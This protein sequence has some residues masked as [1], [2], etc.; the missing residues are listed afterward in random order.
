MRVG[1]LGPLE[2]TAAGESVEIGGVRL[3]V[4]L[5]RLA[6]GTGRVV[7]ADELS[8][9]LWPEEQPADRANAVRSLVARLRRSL[10]D[11]SVLRSDRGGYRLDLPPD[12]V[13]AH[14]FERL[15][16]AGRRALNGG[17]PE[18]AGPLL[19]EAL[20]LWRGP[21]LADAVGAP[22]ATA[23]AAGLEE[24]RLA[25]IEDRAEAD[26]ASGRHAHLV[27]ELSEAAIRHPLR[28]RLQGLL[29]RALHAQGRQAEALAGYEKIRFRLAEELG[30]D[31]GPELREIHR[32]LLQE[33][34]AEPARPQKGNLRTALTSFVGRTAEVRRVGASLAEGRLVTLVGPGGAGK[35]RL[36]TTVAGELAERWPGGAWLVELAAVTD[37]ADVPQAVLG[38]LGTREVG[39]L[40]AQGAPRDTTSRLAEALS[41]AETLIMLDNCEH[42]VEAVA[43]LAED[44]LGRCPELRVLAT[45]REPLGILGEV[46]CPVAPLGLPEPDASARQAVTSPAVR[47]LAE[48]AAAVR[49]GFVVTEENVA[50]VVEICRRLDGLPLAIELAAARMRSLTA[51]QVAE[52]LGDRF[53][54]LTGGSRT[55]LP[56][57]RTLRAVVDWSWDLLGGERRFAERL[58]VFPGGISVEAAERVCAEPGTALDLLGALVDRS[59]LQVVEAPQ[60][61]FRMLETIREYGLER[62][63]ENG[64]I[65]RVR[66]AH[67]AYFLD[68]AETAEPFLRE[69]RQLV[70]MA[71]LEAE[72]DNLLAALHFAADAGD[73]D[74]AVR[75]AA[76]L[77]TFWMMRENYAEAVVRLR[78]ALDVPGEVSSERRSAATAFHMINRMLSGEH[79]GLE[80]IVERFR[81]LAGTIDPDTEDPFLAL[82]EPIFTI[83]TDD[84]VRGVAAVERRMSHPDPWTRAM[85]FMIRSALLEN[86]GEQAGR[87]RDLLAATAGFRDL[88]DRWGLAQVL[89]SLAEAH[90]VFGDFDEAVE[91]MEEAIRLLGELNPDDP[92]AHQRIMLAD[93]RAQQGDVDRARAELLAMTRS[94]ERRWSRRNIA[95]AWLALGDLAR[96]ADDLEGAQRHYEAAAT[97]IEGIGFVAPQFRALILQA[98]AHLAVDRRDPVAAERWLTE[99]TDWAVKGKDMPVLARVGV[100]AAALRAHRGDLAGAA[101]TL[102][103]AERLR[104]APDRFNR[105]IAELTRRLRDALG[106]AAYDAAHARGMALDRAAALDQVRRR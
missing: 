59:L 64:E 76:A 28:E 96:R 39:F 43:H 1:I 91:A 40:D 100:A 69:E 75:L 11:A 51:P 52:R 99:A 10:P 89:S 58:A 94:G 32:A 68:L 82:V 104:G 63:A 106:D 26:L 30:A 27:A 17:D 101:E 38:A 2:V 78:L 67:A 93:A 45:S 31:P 19:G 24:A 23:Y 12:A 92:A 7:T 61:R 53:R 86:E 37:T 97:G 98:M 36:A 87:R 46:L 55:A 21:A 71:V 3:R 35:T 42:L 57:H 70:W 15:A 34:R 88:G 60:P 5:I 41:R 72:H 6:L 50:A 47:L 20:A 13:D 33:G 73:A 14:R 8:D 9:A 77:S 48:R 81:S 102:G 29:L 25:A 22:F 49:P 44:L 105:E 80:D 56:R 103:A 85:L 4:L 54:L 18:V 62:L 16:R 90:L 66:A 79:E 83:F 84:V 65:A 95:F 74:T